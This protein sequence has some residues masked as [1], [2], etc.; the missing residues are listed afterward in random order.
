MMDSKI[1]D[2]WEKDLEK[3]FKMFGADHGRRREQLM[4][5]L[6]GLEYQRNSSTIAQRRPSHM[7][8][9]FRTVAAIA[10]AI[11]IVFGMMLILNLDRQRGGSQAAW[12]AAIEQAGRIQSVHFRL[13]TPGGGSK[14]SLEMWWRPPHEFRMEVS[15]GLIMT[16]NIEKICI[17]DPKSGKLLIDNAGKPGPEMFILGHLGRLFASEPSFSRNWI[18]S[19]KMISSEKVNYKGERCRKVLVEKGSRYYEY[20]IDDKAGADN[21]APFYEVKEYSNSRNGALVSHMEV[22]EVNQDIS[23]SLF[24]IKATDQMKVV[25]MRQP[26]K[27]PGMTRQLPKLD[28]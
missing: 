24:T 9:A 3:H 4:D 17:L 27:T 19:S 18:E 16:G 21:K 5:S 12:A 14:T 15:N 26:G 20:I 28:K 25:D 23:E 7:P 22:L 6:G 13:T 11:I 2:S 1:N 8:R 10:A